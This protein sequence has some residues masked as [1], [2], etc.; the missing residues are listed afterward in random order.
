MAAGAKD[1][2]LM[3]SAGL[4]YALDHPL[5]NGLLLTAS[6]G[7]MYVFPLDFAESVSRERLAG[8]MDGMFGD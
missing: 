3:G 4:N 5:F 8:Q 6:L 1:L 2:I 7:H